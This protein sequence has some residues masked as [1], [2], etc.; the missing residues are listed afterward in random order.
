MGVAVEVAAASRSPCLFCSMK[1]R[2]HSRCN[3]RSLPQRGHI[4]QNVRVG[5]SLTLI[6]RKNVRVTRSISLFLSH[7]CT[8]DNQDGIVRFPVTAL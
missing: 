6:R 4:S 2:C 1:L 5:D 3:S 8:Y 7:S